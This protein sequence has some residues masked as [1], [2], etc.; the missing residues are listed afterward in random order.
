MNKREKKQGRRNYF[1]LYENF[2]H[3]A[4]QIVYTN[5]CGFVFAGI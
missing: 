5:C 4:K 2:R 3:K 1:S